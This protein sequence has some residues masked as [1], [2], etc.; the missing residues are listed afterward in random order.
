MQELGFGLTVE[1]VQKL[2]FDVPIS[3]EYIHVE[4]EKWQISGGGQRLKKGTI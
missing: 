2:E 3:V 4:S 1:Q